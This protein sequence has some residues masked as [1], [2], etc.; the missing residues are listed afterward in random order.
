MPSLPRLRFILLLLPLIACSSP[1]SGGPG[2]GNT[3]TLGVALFEGDGQTAVGH[4]PVPIAPAVKVTVDGTPKAGVSVS[5]SVAKGGGIVSGASATT[6]S[7]GLA[8]PF[9]WTLGTPGAEQEL[10]ATVAGA[11]GSP[12]TFSAT[13]TVGPAASLA[14]VTG[15]NQTQAAGQAAPTSP[16]VVV[17]DAGDNPVAA[18]AVQWQVTGGNGSVLTP[19]ATTG[20]DGTAT[21]GSWIFGQMTGAQALDVTACGGCGTVTFHGTAT[22]GPASSLEKTAGDFQAAPAASDVPI[23]PAVLLKDLYGNLIPGAA[24]AFA[25]T[26]GG[27]SV[28]GGSATTGSDGVATLGSW[29]LGATPGENKL[30]A[31]AGALT[32]TFTATGTG[33]FNPAPFVGTYTGTWN[34]T[35]FA[36]TGS[37][38]AVVTVNSGNQTA[39]VLASATGNVLGSGGGATPP[40]QNGGYTT[41]GAHFNGTVSP[42]GTID[43]TI[44]ADGTITAVGT[45]VPNA[46]ITGWT[47]T[48]TITQHTLDLIFT[49][50]FTA[51]PPAVGTIT[52]TKP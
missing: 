45:N 17:R 29:T 19:D 22:P 4:T 9:A 37:G 18:A 33:A 48:G 24:V 26:Q 10:R 36:T 35:T 34:N 14:I 27:G 40:I 12:V 38:T 42:M 1:S 46:T 21:V 31:T 11:Q 30:T 39:S 43:A 23:A 20:N 6:G 49:V 47:A 13:A 15:D 32:V 44:Q 7:D 51:G 16:V 3:E 25:V 50:T 8:R 41:N 52:M 2:G 28:V 5:F